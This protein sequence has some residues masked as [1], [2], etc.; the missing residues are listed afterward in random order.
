MISKQI[1]FSFTP[2]RKNLFPLFFAGLSLVCSAANAADATHQ[3]DKIAR[4]SAQAEV[5]EMAQNQGW[6]KYDLQLET[7]LPT[8][9]STLP[10]C[11]KN[12]LATPA[13]RRTLYRLRYDV[14]CPDAQGWTQTVAVKTAVNLPIVVALQTLD[15][16]RVIDAQDVVLRVQDIAPLNAQFFTTTEEAIGQTV[17][18]RITSAQIVNSAQL[19]QPIMVERGQSVLMVAR[20]NGIEA[21]TSGEAMKQGRKGDVIR[22]KNI[23]SQRTVDAIVVSPG[24]VHIL[25][26]TR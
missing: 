5:K 17:K 19:E 13:A 2:M 22:V 15:R 24:V 26:A 11:K 3:L 6:G 21:S 9:A 16:G 1:T 10:A 20:Q 8:E 23:S 12:L 14:T 7:V 25:V 18:R 4:K